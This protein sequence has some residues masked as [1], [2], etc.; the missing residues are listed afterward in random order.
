MKK[1]GKK[2]LIRTQQNI[3]EGKTE[4]QRREERQDKGQRQ[5]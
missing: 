4:K 3:R 5:S 1:K 2:K